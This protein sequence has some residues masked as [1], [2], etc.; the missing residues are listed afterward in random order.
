MRHPRFFQLYRLWILVLALLPLAGQGQFTF[1]TNNGVIRITGY[2]GTNG[3]VVVPSTTNGYPVVSIGD[4][5]FFN[6]TF[7]TSITIPATITNI[8]SSAFNS[9]AGLTNII[10]PNSVISIGNLAFGFCSG[11]TN[12][13]ASQGNPAYS[14]V[15]GVLLDSLQGTLVQF[16]PGL[17]GDYAVPNSVSN[18]SAF[19]FYSCAGLTNV[20]LSEGVAS[21]TE[22][23]FGQ[24]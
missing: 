18:I 5:A 14:S 9:C 23:A 19:A 8:G 21:I 1:T 4:N 3:V 10:V 22:R 15:G 24:C 12:I 7:I 13:T 11:L 20:T 6:Q 16:P 17:S 2:T